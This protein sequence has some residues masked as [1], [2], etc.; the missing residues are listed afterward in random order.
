VAALVTILVVQDSLLWPTLLLVAGTGATALLAVRGLPLVHRRSLGRRVRAGLWAGILATV[1]YDLVRYAFVALLAM[2]TDPFV[3]FPLF[4]RLL[5]GDGAPEVALWIAGVSFH[6]ANGLGFAVGYTVVAPRPHVATAVLWALVLELFT[7]W[8][9]P[10]WL[11]VRAV[12]ELVSMSM[13]GHVVYG[14]VLGV[15]SVRMEGRPG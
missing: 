8:L 9:Y 14:I 5:V 10:G 15:V 2:S 12:D 4:G 1:A 6:L 13:V 11:G 3:A 7:I